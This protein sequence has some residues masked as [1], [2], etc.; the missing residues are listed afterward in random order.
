MLFSEPVFVFLFLPLLFLVYVVVPRAARNTILLLASLLFYAWGEKFFVLVMIGS[1]AFNYLM[2]LLIEAGRCRGLHK[3]FLVLG[4]VGNL[5]LLIA[6][7][8]TSFLVASLNSALVGLKMQ[9]IPLPAIHLPIGISFFTFHAM[10]YITDI[11]R[12]KA[13]VQ[14]DPVRI[15]LYITLFPQLIAGPIIRYHDIAHQLA[16]RTVSRAGFAEGIRR[17]ILG[18]GKKMLVANV[19]AVPADQIFAIPTSQLTTPVAWLGVVCYT[20]Q[21]YFDFSGY[22]DM[23]IGLARM[24]GFR[25]LEN[26]NYPYISRTITEFWHRWHISLSNWYRDYLYIPLGGNRRGTGRTYLNLVIVF[27]LCGLWH[28][29]S[30]T[31]VVWGLF[32]GLFLVVERLG[33]GRF[34]ASRRPTV[35]HVYALLVILMSWVLFRSNTLS[36]AAGML[37]AMAGFARGTGLEYHLS[38][39]IDAE[40]A[41][42]LIVG[43]VASTPALPLLAHSLRRRRKVLEL[44]A[45]RQFDTLAAVGELGLLMLIFLLSLSWMAAGTYSPFLYFRF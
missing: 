13:A 22:S 7:K 37:A 4:I 9:P 34:L 35:Q 16:R 41:I 43:V 42:A 44:A 18:L 24:F 25:F 2:G 29:A 36:Q 14:K 15:A 17:F 32:H 30:W 1:I 31:F 27:F 5:G 3:L 33:P 19:V 6:F 12:G 20:L 45:R 39:Y 21:I 28:G 26:F 38:L 10:S 8:Y 11:Y 23:A 40:V